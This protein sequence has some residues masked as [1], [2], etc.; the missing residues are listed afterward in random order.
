[1]AAPIIARPSVVYVEPAPV[2]YYR[3][4]PAI[5]LDFGYGGRHHHHHHHGHHGHW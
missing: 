5:H 1:V 4:A 2:Y 3:P